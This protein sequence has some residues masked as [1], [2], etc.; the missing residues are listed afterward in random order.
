ME[1]RSDQ[2]SILIVDDVADNL[3]L[4][5]QILLQQQ[6]RVRAVSNGEQALT[7]AAMDPPDLILLDIMMPGLDGYAVCERLKANVVTQDIPIIFI[8]ALNEPLDK[9]KAFAIGGVDYITKPFQFEEVLARVKTHLALRHLYQ[10][11]TQEIAQR[12]QDQATLRRYAD[13]LEM[14]NAE[15]DAFAHTV[16]HDLKNPLSLLLGYSY[17]MQDADGVWIEELHKIGAAIIESALKMNN[18]I[19]EL[20][21]LASVRNVDRVELQPVAMSRLIEEAQK[22]IA[23]LISTR[24][25]HIVAPETWPLAWGYGPW[26]EEVW[27]NYLSNAIKYGGTPPQVILGFSIVD[28]RLPTS[29]NQMP[30]LERAAPIPQSFIRFWV[31][32][33]GAG[34]SPEQQARLF[35]PFE[36]LH[37]ARTEGHGLGLSIVRRIVEKLGGQVG[38][39]STGVPGEGC[40]FY[41]TLPSAP[42]ESA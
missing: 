9:V 5:S 11:L 38:V 10:S 8:S 30:T 21:L 25:P 29:E 26:I 24:Q 16:A 2:V 36:R 42:K 13:E 41:F 34:L 3:R 27:V 15:L 35:T 28:F 6:Y 19:D 23:G 33:N 14:Q 18:I 31:R 40:T 22:R 32:D 4:L 39:E 37:Q 7:A 12:R 20:L 1:S 17:M